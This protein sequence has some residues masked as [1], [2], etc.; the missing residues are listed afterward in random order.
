MKL[1]VSKSKNSESFYISKSYIDNTG[2]STT[3][4]VRKLGTLSDLLVEHGPTR[5]DVIAWCRSEV[6]AETRKYKQA[7]QARSVQVVFHADKEMEYG[8][9]KLFEGGYLFLQAIYYKLQ[10]DKVC[11]KIKARHLYEYDLNAILSD[12]VYNRILDPRS[13]LSAYRA[14]QSFLEA[15]SYEIHDVYRAL[16]VLAEESDFIQAEAFKNSHYFGKRNDRIL[17]YDCSNFYFEIEQEDGDKKYGKSKEH[18]PNPIVQMGLFIDGDGIPLAFSIFPGN[19]NEQKSLKPLEIKILRQFGHDK[20]IYCSDAGLGST[21]NR[22]F[23]HIGE[24]AFIVTQSIKKLDREN[25][26]LALNKDG[27]KRLSDGKRIS[28]QEMENDASDELY[29]KEIPYISGDIDQILIV[30]YSPKY[31][32]Y[33]KTIR[34]AQVE[35]ANAMI[36][37]GS[38]KK[39]RNNPND[40]ARFIGKDACTKEGEVAD[41]H[42]YLDESKVEEEARYDGLY[43]VCTDLIDDDVK[44]ILQVSEGRWQIEECFR[45]MK[46]DFSARPI[47]VRRSDRIKAHFLICFL[48]LLVFRLLEKQLGN[49]YTCEEILDKLKSIRFTDIK[50]QGY[51]PTYIRDSLTDD[52][53]AFCGFKTDFE[54]ITKSDMRS[55][56]KMSKQR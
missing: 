43:A 7:R 15:P 50:G 27:F 6:A 17:Y 39:N 52:L 49:Q 33:Q 22:K 14:A 32:A 47:Y 48:A 46:T 9:R 2:K 16:T 31:A 45:I 36:K 28:A 34:D 42:Y 56:K 26:E 5:E 1:T 10:M 11:K 29:Y 40:P 18:R 8:Q 53:H 30:T 20:F 44:S 41:I 12:L 21:A 35:R 25:R 55:I 54:F 19:E 13:K 51:M 37:K 24:R 4:T 3:T 38:M 23:N